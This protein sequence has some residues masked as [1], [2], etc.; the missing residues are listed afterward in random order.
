MVA[1]HGVSNVTAPYDVNTSTAII[2][3][4]IEPHKGVIIA[5]LADTPGAPNLNSVIA[6]PLILQ[7]S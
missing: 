1:F 6:G 7:Q 5:V 4:N 2:P 3:G